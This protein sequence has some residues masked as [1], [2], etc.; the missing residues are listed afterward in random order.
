MLMGDSQQYVYILDALQILLLLIPAKV[1]MISFEL[2]ITSLLY[3]QW[4]YQQNRIISN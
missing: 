3:K 4:N 2:D 1:D